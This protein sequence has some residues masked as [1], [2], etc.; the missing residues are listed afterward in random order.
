MLISIVSLGGVAVL[1]SML[2][3]IV[4]REFQTST[5]F[6]YTLGKMIIISVIEIEVAIMAANGPSLKT[7][8]AKHISK[9]VYTG[10]NQYGGTHKLSNLSS[11][12]KRQKIP[13]ES[14][15]HTNKYSPGQLVQG[16]AVP[17]QEEWQNDSEEKLCKNEAGIIVTSTVGIESHAAQ[18]SNEF[19]GTYSRFDR[20]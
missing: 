15:Y 14:S 6:T 8:W 16:R 2:R 19:V 10:T 12:Q 11:G 1:V 9:T 20:V 13:S 4:L 17:T 7:V 18:N 3:L 5:D